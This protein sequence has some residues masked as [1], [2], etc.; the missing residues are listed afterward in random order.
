[1]PDTERN[2]AAPERDVPGVTDVLTGGADV[3]H[4]LDPVAARYASWL[5]PPG[6][7]DLADLGDEDPDDVILMPMVL[8]IERRES[9]HR[10][11]LLAAAAASAVAVCLDERSAAGGPWHDDLAA[12]TTRRIRKVARRARGSH[13]AAVQQLPGRTCEVG[14]AQ[15]RSFLPTRVADMPKELSRLQ[16]SGSELDTDEPGPAP[17]CCG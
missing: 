14:G 9:P 16:I 17:R 5:A 2:T 1:M 8:R 4:V 7:A 12:W 10:S 11:A 6:A 3:R 13:W 15:V